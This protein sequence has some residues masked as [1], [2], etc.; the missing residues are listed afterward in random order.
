MFSGTDQAVVEEA[1]N[2]SQ[3][4]EEAVERL[5][6]TASGAR[7]IEVADD[8]SRFNVLYMYMPFPNFLVNLNQVALINM[9][10]TV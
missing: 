8:E 5:L 2:N 7:P 6:E 9:S 1:I 10:N 4:P 3:N